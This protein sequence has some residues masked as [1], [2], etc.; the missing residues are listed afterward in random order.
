MAP[1]R[2]WINFY[3]V[4]NALILILSAHFSLHPPQFSC[5]KAG[6]G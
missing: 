2:V 4:L 5:L 1:V 6:R 3:P